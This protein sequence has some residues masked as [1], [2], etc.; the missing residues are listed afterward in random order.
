MSMNSL[1][2]KLKGKLL[3]SCQAR[4]GD[5][6][7][8]PSSMARFAQSVVAGG[9]AGIRANGVDNIRAIRPVVP[10]PIIGI[11]KRLQLDG[12][13]LITPS[14]EG[15]RDVVAAGADF[16][17]LDC[18]ARGRSYGALERLARIKAELH[19]PVMADIATIE[20]A[21]AAEAAGADFILS[22]MRGYTLETQNVE[23]FELDFVTELARATRVPIIAEGKIETPEQAGEAL[24]AGAFAVVVGKA[25]TRP[26]TITERFVAVMQRAL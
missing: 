22:T 21:V 3:V 7:C 20:E 13:I 26:Q 9:A 2:L 18:T 12:Q 14:L 23:L 17:A 5:A 24:Q 25:I 6:F 1:S 16:I 8:D 19:V 15:A 4:P 11:D 10:V